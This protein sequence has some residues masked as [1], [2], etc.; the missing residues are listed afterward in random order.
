MAEAY[1]N[2]TEYEEKMTV[3]IEDLEL[4]VEIAEK[5][6]YSAEACVKEWEEAELEFNGYMASIVGMGLAYE[7]VDTDLLDFKAQKG[8]T[9]HETIELS[10]TA[11]FDFYKIL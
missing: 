5:N 1:K 3:V 10:K 7:A 2:L 11:Y 9:S 6:Y 4:G 8:S